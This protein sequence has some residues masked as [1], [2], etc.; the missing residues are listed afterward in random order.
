MSPGATERAA[1]AAALRAA[2]ETVARNV[3]EAFLAR[4]PDWFERYG[5][6]AR[7]HGVADALFHVD[8]LAGAVE[9]GS[10]PA[11]AAYAAWTAG[12]LRA[13][14]IAPVF[15]QENLAQVQDALVSSLPAPQAQLVR[16]IVAAGRA[17]C[18]APAEEVG[19][20]A[21]DLA[22]AR[23]TFLQAILAGQRAA[24]ANVALLALRTHAALDVYVE[25]VQEAL[26]AVGRAWEANRITVAQEH[27]ATAV[28]QFV[29][30]RMFSALPEPASRQG[31]AVVT[32]VEGERHQIGAHIVSDVLESEGWDVSFL[33]VD[34]PHEGV[35]KAV[36]ELR[37]GVL[38]ISATMLFNLP[39]AVSLVTAVRARFGEARPRIVLGGGAFR[40]AA[41]LWREVGADGCALDLRGALAITGG[42]RGP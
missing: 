21:G 14:G 33:G 22:L 23:E 15:L 24:A 32:G 37:P 39:K 36:E 27:R 31:R 19:L 34:T 5:D 3:T 4:H 2:R 16:E 1:A 41:G 7:D 28:A 11:F 26:Y 30:A 8:F 35:L 18:A 10:A 17:A 6:R 9:A 13:R 25:V 38:G 42:F 20:P 12:V 40:H 29:V